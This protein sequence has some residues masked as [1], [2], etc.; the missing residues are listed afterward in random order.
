MKTISNR[1]E[2]KEFFILTSEFV[3]DGVVDDLK[4]IYAV[5]EFWTTNP[6]WGDADDLLKKLSRRVLE[7]AGTR[8]YDNAAIAFE[9]VGRDGVTARLIVIKGGNAASI[10]LDRETLKR[11]ATDEP[12]EDATVTEVKA[13]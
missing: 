13:A 11:I 4:A 10:I 2:L 7:D 9:N 12:T 1:Q 8:S 6:E 5:A 3:T